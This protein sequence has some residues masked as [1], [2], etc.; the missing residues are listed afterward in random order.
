MLCK[1]K[2]GAAFAPICRLI[3]LEMARPGIEAQE[4]QP[5]QGQGDENVRVCGVGRKGG[6]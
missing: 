2:Y 6:G 5:G 1:N 4:Q 3:D